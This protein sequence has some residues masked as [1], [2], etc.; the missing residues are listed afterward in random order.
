MPT[1]SALLKATPTVLAT[2][3]AVCCACAAAR[4]QQK[5]DGPSSSS[6][7][8]PSASPADAAALYEDASKFLERRFA[9]YERKRVPFSRALEAETREEQRE[10][11]AA[12]AARLVQ[13]GRLK[14]AD[15]F[16]LALLYQ[17]AG[18]AA[19]SIESARLFVR[20]AKEKE[21]DRAQQ[22]RQIAAA[23][24]AGLGRL[25]EAEA[26]L[27]EYERGGPAS[28][29]EMFRLR[30]ALMRGYE[31][32]KKLAE[33]AA[34]A[35]EAFRLAKLPATAGS[36]YVQRAAYVNSS[37][38]SL[39]DL[40]LRQK[41]DA[42]A[43]AVMKELLALGLTLPSAHVYSNAVA[44]LGESGH[45]GVVE[46]SLAEPA[47]GGDAPELEVAQ[48]IDHKPVKLADLRGRVVLLD[49]WATWCVPCRVTM[50]QLSRLHARYG[51]RGLT[52]VG[53]TQLEGVALGTARS[54]A[55]ELG[56]LRAFKQ[57]LKLP[58][59]FAV[60]TNATNHLRYGVRVIPTAFLIDRR[61]RVRYIE[62]GASGSPD[63]SLARVI[64]RL[65]DE[66]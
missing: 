2:A 3:L 18:K 36:D 55:E 47:A 61:G 34:H 42:E 25:T 53:L 27:A 59:G 58:Y 21:R 44:L 37:G 62:A 4:A 65:L 20:E 64:E 19:E 28:G 31:R 29:V 16:Y 14:G 52:V 8:A 22:A 24:L 40:L 13:R 50:P 26:A 43:L 1:R 66:K 9:E 56:Q 7:P 45:A 17:L 33:S 41:R 12:H 11:A 54:A 10:L 5:M 15:H 46:K 48:W 6:S 39:A 23:Q 60:S 32:E 35:A 63:A 49:F 30:I 38:V 51:E 57:E